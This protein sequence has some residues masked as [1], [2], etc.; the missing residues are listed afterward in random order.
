MME[1]VQQLVTG[2][3]VSASQVE[4]GAGLLCGLVKEQLARYWR[5]PG[6]ESVAGIYHP[7]RLHSRQFGE[8]AEVVQGLVQ[9]G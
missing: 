7:R 8:T 2:T 3:G 9:A 6:A 5:R 1:L 4:G